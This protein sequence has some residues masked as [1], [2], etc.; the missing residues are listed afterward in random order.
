MWDILESSFHV[1]INEDM[2]VFS[3]IRET[4]LLLLGRWPL[5]LHPEPPTQANHSSHAIA[6]W[7]CRSVSSVIGYKRRLNS[8]QVNK[9]TSAHLN[10]QTY[11]Q[12]VWQPHNYNINTSTVISVPSSFY[13]WCVHLTAFWLSWVSAT[14]PSVYCGKCFYIFRETFQ[15]HI[16]GWCAFKWKV[17]T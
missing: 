5:Q 17:L 1:E 10:A 2:S 8:K 15:A 12:Q 11:L 7:K 6:V 4:N 3:S 13:L 16:V 14:R 9:V